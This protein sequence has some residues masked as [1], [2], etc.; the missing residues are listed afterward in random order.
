MIESEKMNEN[1]AASKIQRIFK[2]YINKTFTDPI[3][4]I[5]TPIK[6]L[7]KLPIQNSNNFFYF[8]IIS[9]IQWLN[10]SIEFINPINNIPFSTKHINIIK[11]KAKKFNIEFNNSSNES[12][13]NT[14]IP[15]IFKNVNNNIIE[16]QKII[17]QIKIDEEELINQAMIGNIEGV[18]DIVLKNW[19]NIQSDKFNINTKSN[20]DF[21][22]LNKENWTIRKFTPLM[23]AS[24]LG[25][26]DIVIFLLEYGADYDLCE[27]AHGFNA[28][29]LACISDNINIMCDLKMYGININNKSIHD[30][31]NHPPMNTFEF[32][33]LL[34]KTDI[35]SIF[36]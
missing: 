18:R 14:H 28:F 8:N 34:Q 5:E 33:N 17:K 15:T 24:Y 21:N 23:I 13:K 1:M 11:N 22:L 26:S 3:Y 25:F 36:E 30:I 27:I 31:D 6:F 4:N 7:V 2:K 19:E 16:N 9:L 20:N 29:H 35:L 32:F 12:S 10:I